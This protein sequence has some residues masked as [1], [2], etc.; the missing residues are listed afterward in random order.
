MGINQITHDKIF[1]L[2]KTMYP[3]EKCFVCGLNPYERATEKHNLFHLDR[4]DKN[5]DILNIMWICKSCTQL[6]ELR[7]SSKLGDDYVSM[8]KASREKWIK[9]LIKRDGFNCQI[10][11]RSLDT[12]NKYIVDHIDNTEHNDKDDV[13]GG[14]LQLLCHPCNISKNPPYS[15]L[16][17]LDVQYTASMKMFNTKSRLFS[18]WLWDRIQIDKSV[19]YDDAVESGAEI[20]R[21][22]TETIKRYIRPLCSSVGDF[23]RAMDEYGQE[24]IYEKGKSPK[25]TYDFQKNQFNV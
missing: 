7:K 18:Q 8:N 13:I 1:A 17:N 23:E 6:P 10:C 15:N 4:N 22:S 11:K 12:V 9:F 21:C 16:G 2:L 3:E 14:N 19:G 5:N 24:R 25:I 20:C